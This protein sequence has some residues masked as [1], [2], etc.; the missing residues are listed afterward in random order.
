[1]EWSEAK[2]SAR[3][4]CGQTGEG[5]GEWGNNREGPDARYM[6]GT[7]TSRA[8]QFAG[9]KD[10]TRRDETVGLSMARVVTFF[11]PFSFYFLSFFL[12]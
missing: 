3:D 7:L 5:N 9:R 2:R 8:G 11:L 1:M 10:V 6:G 12:S 4:D